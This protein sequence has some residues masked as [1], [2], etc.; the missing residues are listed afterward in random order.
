MSQQSS[1]GR[2][3]GKGTPEPVIALVC[4]LLT[5]S[6]THPTQCPKSGSRCS[7]PHGPCLPCGWS[8]EASLCRLVCSSWR[9]SCSVMD[10][11]QAIE[12]GDFSKSRR[13]C[14]QG[15]GRNASGLMSRVPWGIICHPLPAHSILIHSRAEFPHPPPPLTNLDVSSCVRW[16]GGDR[17]GPSWPRW[18]S[19]GAVQEGGGQEGRCPAPSQP[20]PGQRLPGWWEAPLDFSAHTQ[21]PNTLSLQGQGT[22]SDNTPSPASKVGVQPS[23]PAQRLDK[24]VP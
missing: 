11:A 7:Y 24:Q 14:V 18:R 4:D 19:Q 20:E 13:G 17:A 9:R 1:A 16:T 12:L 3:Q 5:W 8:C 6:N 2:A 21:E 22:R 23:A 10:S 15:H